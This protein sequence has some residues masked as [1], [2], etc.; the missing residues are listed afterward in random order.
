MKAHK[1]FA[2]LTCICFAATMITGMKKKKKIRKVIEE[3]TE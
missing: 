1:T 3:V 2:C